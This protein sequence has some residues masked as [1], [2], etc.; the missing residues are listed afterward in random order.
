VTSAVVETQNRVRAVVCQARVDALVD[1]HSE[2][3]GALVS[4]ADGFEVAARLRPEVSSPKVAAMTSSLV[5][6]AEAISGEGGLGECRDLV[7]DSA[8]GRILMMD[9]PST[10]GRLLLTVFCDTR[11][12]LGQ[13]LWAVRACRQSLG[14]ELADA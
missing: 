13:V 9:V 2:I 7:V 8:M 11:A 10:G 3:S 5:A 1:E 12:T 6:L 14:R 4:T